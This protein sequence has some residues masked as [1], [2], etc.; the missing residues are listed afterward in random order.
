MFTGSPTLRNFCGCRRGAVA[1][2]FGLLVLVI[3]IFVG[4]S[5]D[6][7]RA[8][9]VASTA[10]D[11]LDAAALAAA[12]QLRLE[13]PSDAELTRTVT[14]YFNNNFK[15]A[16]AAASVEKITVASDRAINSIHLV[17]DL[18]VPA[19]L[20]ALLGKSYM[21]I[22]IKS[23][24]VF[25]VKN[26][27]VSMMLDLSGSMAGNKLR[28]LKA[29]AGDLVNIM[30]P[31]DKPHDNKIAIAPFATAVNAGDLAGAISTGVDARG[32]SM[33]GRWTTCVTERPGAFAFSERSASTVKLHRK[34][35]S[36]PSSEV[37]PLS[38]D[39]EELH[40][41]IDDMQANGMT[42]GHLGIAWAWYLLSPDWSDVL[43]DR[44]APAAYSDQT[45]RKVALIMTDGMFNTS[46][47]N[48]N[49]NSVTQARALCDN[50]KSAG[51]TI[52]TVGFQVPEEVLP[53]LEH[54]ATSPK[55]H[56]TAEDG[57]QLRRTFQDIANRL[58]G[59]RLSS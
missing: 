24:A 58:N 50:M 33:S 56:Y 19:T 44:S 12:K 14:N 32:R 57:A 52:F 36:C 7:A 1:P 25:D 59:L 54:C 23:D 30:L 26:V 35:S 38:N 5:V 6:G 11:A 15:E 41:E 45:V 9:R 13:N 37:V 2:L 18:K 4:I 49:G 17:V 46:Y 29:A 27:E 55:H 20:S 31:Q 21:S 10:R 51:I 16:R 22:K 8:T 53:T 43:P 34:S 3:L 42:A 48:A 28:D 39:V 40:D 47:E